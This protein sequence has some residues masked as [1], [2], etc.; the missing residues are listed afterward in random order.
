MKR[1]RTMLLVLA[2]VA[3]LSVSVYAAKRLWSASMS[4]DFELHDVIGSNAIGSAVIITKPDG[5]AWEFRVKIVG[6]SGVPSGVS[7]HGWATAQQTAP[8]ILGLC[9]TPGPSVLAN[10]AAGYDF[11]TNTLE[12]TGDITSPLLMQWG[13]RGREFQQNLS[14]GLVYVSAHT[15][16]NTLGECRGQFQQIFP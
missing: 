4:A 1:V 6:L 7:L 14:A 2:A 13:L 9:G 12:I 10:C 15:A 11:S 3:G 8:V 16:L 5:S